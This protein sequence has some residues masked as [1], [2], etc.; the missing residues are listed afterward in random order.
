MLT[1]PVP[2]TKGCIDVSGDGVDDDEGGDVDVDV[3]MAKALINGNK[4]RRRRGVGG[5]TD[6]SGS[7]L[8]GGVGEA[9]ADRLL[10]SA[11]NKDEARRPTPAKGARA[12][13]GATK[14]TQCT[15][16]GAVLHA[17][18]TAVRERA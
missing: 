8:R 15:A 2:S 3:A 11:A 10:R 17:A 5:H 6:G 14:R 9:L 13:P 12:T 7:D 18:R 1:Q 4:A 16:F